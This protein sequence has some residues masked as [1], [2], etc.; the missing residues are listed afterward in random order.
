MILRY[1][2]SKLRLNLLLGSLWFLIGTSKIIFGDFDSWVDY[3][4]L[5]LALLY[6]GMY[7]YEYHYQYYSIENGSITR[8]GLI[9]KKMKLEEISK[10]TYAAGDFVLQG[11]ED[12]FTI[13][14]DL[15][16]KDS[17]EDLKQELQKFG[18]SWN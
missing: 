4:W 3:C 13:N 15:V 18:L 14:T 11:E 16:D 17:L 5:A 9:R 12:R 6:M 7:F 1:K 2:K 10:V 8:N